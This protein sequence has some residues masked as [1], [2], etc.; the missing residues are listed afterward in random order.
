[1]KEINDALDK[2]IKDNCNIFLE[3]F[4]ATLESEFENKLISPKYYSDLLI[5]LSDSFNVYK[6]LKAEEYGC[7]LCHGIKQELETVGVYKNN[8]G[9]IG[10]LGEKVYAINLYR[11]KTGNMLQLSKSLNQLLLNMSELCVD[12]SQFMTKASCY[13]LISGVSGTL[14]YLIDFQWN[15]INEEK[16]IKIIQYLIF[17]TKHYE[18]KG[19]NMPRFHIQRENIPLEENKIK[20]ADGYLNFGLSHG[21][22]G[23]LITLCKA[24]FNGYSVKGIDEAIKTIFMIYETFSEKNSDIYY[25]PIFLS[26]HDYSLHNVTNDSRIQRAS[27]CYGNIGIVR[28]LYIASKYISNKKKQDKY[29]MYLRNILNGQIEK[30]HLRDP[31]LCHGYSSV[32]AISGYAFYDT[33]DIQLLKGINKTLNACINVLPLDSYGISDFSLLQGVSGIVL[34]LV[35]LIYEQADYGNLLMI[36]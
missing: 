32:L 30:F 21:M 16:I 15:K 13:D 25:W 20:Y 18:Y 9:M 3:N 31:C 33:K 4:K 36:K 8:I 23:P 2:T 34:T 26:P 11:K 1:M 35:N 6:M 14:Y 12:N 17:L 28:G 5:L 29:L 19:I 7:E 10:G 22:L 27:W 24:K